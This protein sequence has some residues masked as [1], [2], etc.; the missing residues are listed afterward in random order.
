[1]KLLLTLFLSLL[2]GRQSVL[3]LHLPPATASS[4]ENQ[5]GA[6]D[7]LASPDT[8]KGGQQHLNEP[9]G[10]VGERRLFGDDDGGDGGGRGD[11]GSGG[12]EGGDKAAGK[13]AQTLSSDSTSSPFPRETIRRPR[14]HLLDAW[15]AR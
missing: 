3:G 13:R 9:G 7:S 8:L 14:R 4:K 10:T 1:M 5:G 6:N 15:Y 11:G 2:A 12:G